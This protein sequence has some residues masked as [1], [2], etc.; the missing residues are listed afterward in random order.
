[1]SALDDV[2]AERRRQIEVEGWS[3]DHDDLHDSGQMA[4]AAAWYTMNASY[5]GRSDCLNDVADTHHELHKI[6]SAEHSAFSW[7]WLRKWWKPK[8]ARHD[9]VKA[10]ALIVAEIERIDRAC[11]P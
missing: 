1:M 4:R 11:K 10:A 2:A 8:N 7:P 6:F 3:A 5:V 9:L